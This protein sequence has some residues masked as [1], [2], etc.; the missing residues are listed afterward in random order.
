MFVIQKDETLFKEFSELVMGV[1]N[2]EED[3][4]MSVM[5]S[6]M[7][8]LAAKIDVPRDRIKVMSQVHSA[9][10]IVVNDPDMNTQELEADAMVTNLTDVVLGVKTADCIPVLLYD[11]VVHAIGVA[12]AGRKGAKAGV[13]K[14]TVKAMVREYGVD[15]SRL[16][17][18]LGPS[19]GAQDHAV[20]AEEVSDEMEEIEGVVVRKND[21]GVHD[22]ANEEHKRAFQERTGITDE[23]LAHKQTVYV[24]MPAFVR[25]QLIELGVK[26]GNIQTSRI[27]TMRDT[28]VHSYRRD[29]PNHGLMLSC[30]GRRARGNMLE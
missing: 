5:E 16:R 1:T 7:E 2:R 18:Y 9:E 29:F 13:V 27:N 30:I 6:A 23:E 25:E 12:H 22:F 3:F 10:V 15:V 24:D 26:E 19:L 20:F 17:V 21:I 28:R 8:R 4:R 11:P 14:N